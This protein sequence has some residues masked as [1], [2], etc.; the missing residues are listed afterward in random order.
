MIARAA[1]SVMLLVCS[2]V[3]FA[4]LAASTAHAQAPAKKIL[5]LTHSAGFKH[6]V[7]PVSEQVLPELG[8]KA[9]WFT[10]DVTQDCSKLNA[11]DL[12]QYDA[13]VFYTTGELP[14]S[15]QQ[16]A[17]LQAFVEGGKGFVGIHSATDTF[18]KWP[19]YGTM[20]GGYFDG[21]P[22]TQKVTI[23]V[24]D[25]KNPSTKHLGASFEIDDEIYQFKEWSRSNVHVLLSLDPASIDLTKKG[26]KRTD[27][28][29]G[30]SWTRTQGKGRVFYTALGHRPEVW[31]DARFQQHLVEGIR[32][33]ATR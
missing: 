28:D 18:Y 4:G 30:I 14:I 17:D 26:V 22:W 9:G 10:V 5:Y 8:T 24:D 19:W 33:A 20:I 7:L 31:Q 11:A 23:K 6:A 2:V 32:W 16:K 25:P 1:R 27:K 15:D 12:K 29:F 3:L 13:V 21:H